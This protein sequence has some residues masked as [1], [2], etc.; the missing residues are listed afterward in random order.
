MPIR[1]ATSLLKSNDSFSA[2]PSGSKSAWP[3]AEEEKAKLFN[4]AQDAVRKTQGISTPNGVSTSPS[5]APTHGRSSSVNVPPPSGMSAGA[6]LYSQALS[7]MARNA[8]TGHSAT[9]SISSVPPT[10]STPQTTPTK[11]P[12]PHY[13]TAEEEKA[14]L[15]RYHEAKAAVDR[16]QS[17]SY[18]PSD[19][20][21]AAPSSAPT[22][23]IL[24]SPLVTSPAV[25][26]PISYDALYPNSTPA[27]VMSPPAP[28]P[29]ELPPSFTPG[30]NGQPTYISEKERL[31]RHHEAQDAAALAAQQQQQR[32]AAAPH[33][34]ANGPPL[35]GYYSPS[36]PPPFTPS[37]PNG[38][39]SQ[40]PLSEKE[41]LRRHL[42]QQDRAAMAGTPP[43]ITP[44][45][46][47]STRG[48]PTPRAQPTPPNPSQGPRPLTAAEEKARLKAMY[49]AEERGAPPPPPAMSP[50]MWS[51]APP[52]P[53]TNGVNGTDVHRRPSQTAPNY[54]TIPPPP[55]LAP[56]PPKEYIQETQEED[57][58]V[59]A[60]IE[61][62]DNAD[63]GSGE[64]IMSRI[65]SST[66]LELRA[67][68]PFQS[69]FQDNGIPQY[70]ALQQSQPPPRPPKFAINDP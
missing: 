38:S 53:Y 40:A 43:P 3:S 39:S 58:N 35:P 52:A 13:P 62:I 64:D 26:S 60:R 66:S 4:Q 34:P 55:P 56:R 42:E 22:P 8:S 25:A 67:F 27:R 68:S 29:G 50:P 30:P 15:R 37:L 54:S 9:S 18:G 1:H 69:G 31:R 5:P 46:S 65:D 28:A 32:Q 47:G 51:P 23:S 24:S 20:K 70:A 57:Q 16:N 45:R 49:E 17:A 10:S 6:A 61:A 14:A 41:I 19:E 11:R 2:R 33:P 12:T 44:P 36:S 59:A 48:L 63:A 7:N 21:P